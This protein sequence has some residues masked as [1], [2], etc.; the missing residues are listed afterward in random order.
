MSICLLPRKHSKRQGCRQIGKIKKLTTKKFN[1]FYHPL[2][3]ILPNTPLQMNFEAQLKALIFFHLEKHESGRHL[4]QVLEED[5]FARTH[6]APAEGIKK[7]G[8][9]QAINS[10]GLEQL[11]YIFG[12][13]YTKSKQTLP[14]NNPELGD[15]IAIDGSLI[16]AVLSMQWANY[17]KT[18]KKAK[19][20]VGYDINRGVPSKIFLTDGNGTERPFV[21][22]ILSPGQTGVMDRGYQCHKDF[23]NWHESGLQF[24]CRVRSDS[25]KTVVKNNLIEPGGTVFYDSI[26]LLGTP[27]KQTKNQLRLVGYKIDNKEYWV[28]TNRFDLSAENVALV[29][30]LRWQIEIFFGW[31]KRHLKVYHL[32]ARSEY[33]LM[34]QILAGL[35]T[36]LLLT[37]Y[38]QN[39]FGEKVSIKRVRQLLNDIRNESRCFVGNSQSSPLHESRC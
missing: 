25:H 38:C 13:L 24:V 31:W 37:N 36:Y 32:I 28:I 4:I 8:F 18:H 16:D 3:S 9:F 35:I 17:S 2:K 21:E 33:G 14:F 7:S 5:N 34:V 23:D 19:V 10:R 30:K 29:Y 12:Q 22:K 6:I 20:H 11:L 15:L 26:I 1:K 39:E 27:K